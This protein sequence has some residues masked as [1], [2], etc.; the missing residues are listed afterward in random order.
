MHLIELLQDHREEI[1]DA[2]F[3][4]MKRTHLKH[5]EE[6]G[7]SKTYERLHVLHGLLLRC[8][9]ERNMGPMIGHAETIGRERFTLGFDL[10]EVQTAYNVLEEAIWV[11]VLKDLDPQE[12]AEALGLVST[13]IGAGKDT[14]ART[15]VS[16]ASRTK[17]PSLNLQSMFAGTDGA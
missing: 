5:Y 6:M 9:A 2:A 13:V 12:M 14:L 1:V 7:E 15:Y 10:Y 3:H 8:V 17:A 16:L 4:A 11:R